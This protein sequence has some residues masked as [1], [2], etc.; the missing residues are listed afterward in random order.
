MSSSIPSRLESGSQEG[1]RAKLA[2]D[3]AELLAESSYEAVRLLFLASGFSVD[4]VNLYLNRLIEDVRKDA[5][6]V[7]VTVFE[8]AEG[9]TETVDESTMQAHTTEMVEPKNLEAEK[10]LSLALYRDSLDSPLYLEVARELLKRIE[11]GTY[12]FLLPSEIALCDEFGYSRGTIRTAIHMLVERG[13][14]GRRQGAGTYIKGREKPE[15]SARKAIVKER[16]LYEQISDDIAEAIINGKYKYRLPTMDDLAAVHKCSRGTIIAAIRKLQQI[17]AV[18]P[19]QGVGI[20]IN[21][22]TS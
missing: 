21:S 1:M 17:G 9:V 8:G 14:V 12:S 6:A 10:P 11:S 18:E 22:T 20:I 7:S 2:L 15:K 4:T 19:K 5:Q 13:I 16:P 3:T